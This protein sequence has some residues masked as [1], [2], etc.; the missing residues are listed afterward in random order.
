MNYTIDEETF[1]KI[2][3]E[4][5]HRPWGAVSGLIDGL[6]Q[7]KDRADAEAAPSIITGI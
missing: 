3:N 5:Q 6:I 4:L 1:I 2:I 7:I